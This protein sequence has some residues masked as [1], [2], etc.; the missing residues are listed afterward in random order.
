LQITLD[1]QGITSVVRNLIENAIK[2]SPLSS[3]VEVNIQLKK[4][5]LVYDVKDQGIG[6]DKR[7]KEKIADK[8]YRVEAE[9]T[10]SYKGT[11]LGLYIVKEIVKM[12][13]GTMQVIDNEP[14]GSVFRIIIPR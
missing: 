8:F 14:K 1:E 6:I 10:R 11:G 2:Y 4:N 7:E 13:E 12:H 3:L 9:K 5:K